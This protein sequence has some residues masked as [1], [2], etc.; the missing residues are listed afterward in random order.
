MLVIKLKDG[1]KKLA[2]HI[3]VWSITAGMEVCGRE[4]KGCYAMKMQ[5]LRPVVADYNNRMYEASQAE[6]FDSHIVIHNKFKYVRIHASGEFYS[7]KYID[8][9]EKIARKHP[10][11]IFYTYTKRMQDF[12]FSKIMALPNCV[13][14]NSLGSGIIN[15]GKGISE[16]AKSCGGFVCPDTLEDK[17]ERYCGEGCT[18]CMQKCNEGTPIFFEKH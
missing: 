15:F 4:C 12:D 3:G 6:N 2:K 5:K 11:I 13:V 7:Q 10:E 9:W 17:G 16:V 14:H 18:W 8:K 1:N